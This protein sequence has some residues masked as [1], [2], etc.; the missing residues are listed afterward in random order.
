MDIDAVTASM[1]RRALQIPVSL[2]CLI[3]ALCGTAP[4]QEPKRPPLRV[5]EVVDAPAEFAPAG[6]RT[7]KEVLKE[8]DLNGDGKPDAALVISNGADAQGDPI[9]VKHVLVLALRGSDGKLHRSVVSDAAVLDRVSLSPGPQPALSLIHCRLQ[10]TPLVADLPLGVV[11]C[12]H[13]K[14][15]SRRRHHVDPG[16]SIS[17]ATR[18]TSPFEGP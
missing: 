4:A 12:A 11:C 17:I 8:A 16:R 5:P 10:Q 9:V 13:P 15:R 14:R 1:M 7:E 18:S 2:A 3:V 6:W